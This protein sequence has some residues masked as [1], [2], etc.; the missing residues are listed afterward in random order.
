MRYDFD[1][2]LNGEVKSALLFFFGLCLIG[3]PRGLSDIAE[4]AQPMGPMIPLVL[5]R[6]MTTKLEQLE[7]LLD[8][9]ST[10]KKSRSC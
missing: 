2:D 1:F 8:S 10:A 7:R 3:R 9:L 5:E 4:I 6:P